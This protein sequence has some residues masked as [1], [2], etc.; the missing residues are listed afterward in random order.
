M[1]Y[2]RDNKKK[3]TKSGGR[4][5]K[6]GPNVILL[7]IYKDKGKPTKPKKKKGKTKGSK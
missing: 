2:M 4:E 1:P 7:P 5:K 6:Q 3:P